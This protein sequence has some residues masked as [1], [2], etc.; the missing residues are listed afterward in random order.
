[1]K[2]RLEET[3]TVDGEVAGSEG[4]DTDG[5]ISHDPIDHFEDSFLKCFKEIEH[6]GHDFCCMCL[7]RRVK[8]DAGGKT[9][10]D[11]KDDDGEKV[12]FSESLKS[13]GKESEDDFDKS[14]AAAG[15][16]GLHGFNLNG[17]FSGKFVGCGELRVEDE[18]NDSTEDRGIERGEKIPG[19]DAE[20]HFS[21]SFCGQTCGA[22]DEGEEDDRNNDHFEHI[23]KNGAEGG[24]DGSD[25][26]NKAFTADG[27][28]FV[29]NDTGETSEDERTEIAV[30][31]GDT[32]V[33]VENFHF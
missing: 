33:P 2:I 14:V 32:G 25:L 17:E 27:A 20:S 9:E 30:D 12:S 29:N 4:K 11:G 1:M 10:H 6:I 7:L 13:I 26:R 22:V 16:V 23:D 28:E 19:T 31:E 15:G 24:E 18:G 5:E 21:E 3:D 8:D